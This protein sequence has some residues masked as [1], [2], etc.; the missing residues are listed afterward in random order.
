MS[1]DALGKKSW[2]LLS[3]QNIDRLKLRN[4]HAAFCARA[5]RGLLILWMEQKSLFLCQCVAETLCHVLMQH[6]Q[7]NSSNILCLK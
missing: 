7:Q 3:V 1:K 2:G 5:T 4:A 6:P